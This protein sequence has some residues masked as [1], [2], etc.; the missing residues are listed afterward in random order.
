MAASVQMISTKKSVLDEV[1]SPVSSEEFL[2]RY[3]GQ[4]FVHVPGRPG[5]FSQ[6]LPWSQLN[7]ILKHHRLRPGRLRLFQDT[8]E[9]PQSSYFDMRDHREPRLKG[10][11]MTSLL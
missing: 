2:G 5:K 9:V 4:S 3:W 6:L 10:T 7:E 8:K 1:L 11:E